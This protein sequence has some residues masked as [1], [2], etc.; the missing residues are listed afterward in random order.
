MSQEQINRDTKRYT[1]A[2]HGVQTGVGH[3]LNHD[4]ASGSPKHLRTGINSALVGQAAI[5]QL[6][7]DKGVF[8]LA[9]YTASLA[10][11]AE[12]ERASYEKTLSTR[13]GTTVHLR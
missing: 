12:A 10:N 1:D 6:L 5:A 11:H 4:P 8:T 9:E 3:E 2:M 7:I 13:L